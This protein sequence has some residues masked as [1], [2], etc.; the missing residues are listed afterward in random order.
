VKPI[1]VLAAC[2]MLPTDAFAQAAAP[3]IAPAA[4]DES[5]E[6]PGPDGLP[7]TV[8]ST[9]S[10]GSAVPGAVGT[11]G[12][13]FR[14]AVDLVALNVVVT[15]PGQRLVDGLSANDFAVFEDG[16]L[17][18]V[19]FFAAR[20]VPLDIALLLDTS[21]SMGGE[22]MATMQK[23]ALGF[24]GTLRPGDRVMIVDIKN[25]TRVLHAL[26]PTSEQVAEAVRAT[27]AGGGTGLYNGLYLT[28]KELAKARAAAGEAVRRQ[29]LVVLSDGQDTSSLMSFDDVME[30]AKDS[31]IAT[32]TVT[33]RAPVL[34]SLER[35]RGSRYFS[36]SEYSMRVLA[37]ETGAQ[38]FFPM[39]ITELDGVYA[40]IAKEL[41]TQYALGYT[42][43]TLRPDGRFRR[44]VV[45][46]TDRPQMRI[47]TRAGYT[48]ARRPAAAPLE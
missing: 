28:Y 8:G 3:S 29:A 38:A 36:Q 11:T 47:R 14:S 35:A 27:R 12:P 16:V 31:G 23:A 5:S 10:A 43:K 13:T 37:Q 39:Q 41:A 21:A 44:I 19:S 18:D 17:Q 48:A 26:A 6:R 45:Q 24:L 33:L 22:K 20:D 15:D 42:P 2:L 30:V 40:A 9:S 32:Y 1:W 7:P 4:L 34:T 25:S 46:V